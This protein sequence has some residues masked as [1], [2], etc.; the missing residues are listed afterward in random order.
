MIAHFAAT[1]PEVTNQFFATIELRAGRLVSIEI[2]DQT[3][4]KRDVV[5]IIAVNVAA[6][7]LP[8]P[9]IAY[10]DLAIAGRGSVADHKVISEPV[11]HSAKMPMVI[12]ES[13]CISLTRPAVM[14][15]DKLPATTR[16]R[17]TSRACT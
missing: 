2:P 6:V 10:F 1:L 15:D 12:I 4:S 8:P 5:E 17:R 11:L 9:T 3:N 7:D 13:G 16:H 14:D